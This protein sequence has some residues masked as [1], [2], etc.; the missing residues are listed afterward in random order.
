MELT[1]ETAS[2]I[3][4]EYVSRRPGSRARDEQARRSLPGGDTRIATYYAPFPTYMAQAHG[5]Y[6]H[7]HDGHQ[8][9]DFLN[10]YSSLVHGHAH[11]A[12]VEAAADQMTRGSVFGAAA[13]YQVELAELLCSRVPSIDLLRFTNSGTEATMMAIRAARAFTRRDVIVKIDGGYHGSH[14]FVEVS[15]SPDAE[16][17]GL[18]QARLEDSGIPSSVLN[19]VLV[20]PFNSLEAMEAVL[21][22]AGDRVAAIIV[23]PLPNAGGMILPEHDYLRGLRDLATQYGALLIFDEIVT[24]RLDR[25]GYQN[26]EAVQPDLTALGKIIGGGFP[27]GAFG[28][29]REIMQQFDPHQPNFLKHT[30]TFNGNNITM[31]AGLTGMQL[32]DSGAIRQIN[33]LGDRMRAGISA[34]FRQ[35]G[36]QGHATGYGSLMQLHWTNTTLRTPKEALL[37]SRGLDQLKTLFHLQL[38]NRGIYIGPRGLITIST[39]MNESII[40][41]ALDVI[42]ETL[43]DLKPTIAE[44]APHLLVNAP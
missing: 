26:I 43:H 22:R 11:P 3:V 7:D 8:Y 36:I 37:A 19:E 32:L 24:F 6:L 25:G 21:S 23:E 14:D 10:N 16:S 35:V 12:I 27:V 33:A 2:R 17:T 39:P 9:V 42:E 20:A 15:V 44:I 4:N 40:D 13:D 41:S 28:G 1:T 18:P 29:R 5:C 34:A 31:V 38:M 30:G